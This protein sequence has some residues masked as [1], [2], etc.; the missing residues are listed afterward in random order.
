MV[1]S[2][3]PGKGLLSVSAPPR[4]QPGAQCVPQRRQ[5]VQCVRHQIICDI[6]RRD[7]MEDLAHLL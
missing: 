5:R 6:W 7:R 1:V 2:D 3:N 4:S